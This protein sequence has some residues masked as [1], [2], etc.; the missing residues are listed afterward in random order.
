MGNKSICSTRLTTGTTRHSY[1]TKGF[2]TLSGEWPYRLLRLRHYTDTANASPDAIDEN[3]LAVLVV[4]IEH[5][6]DHTLWSRMLEVLES[7]VSSG[8]PGDPLAQEVV[9]REFPG[10]GFLFARTRDHR[11]VQRSARSIPAGRVR[12][13]EGGAGFRRTPAEE[14]SMLLHSD[15]GS[16]A[17]YESAAERSERR[18]ALV[19]EL[20]TGDP[21]ALR[22][23][24][25]DA[26]SSRMRVPAILL[27]VDAAMN[28]IADASTLLAGALTRPDDPATA[29]KYLREAYPDRKI[30]ASVKRA[31][32]EAAVRLFDESACI[33]FD[34]QRFRGVED[35][36]ATSRSAS[37]R[38][39]LLVARPAPSSDAQSLLFAAILSGYT[40]VDG[41]PLLQARRELKN[42]EP[43]DAS[44]LIASAARRVT[45]ARSRGERPQE[46]LAALPWSDL[47]ALSS[48]PRPELE[49]LLT[50]GARLAK[51]LRELRRDPA[52]VDTYREDRRLRRR[53]RGLT[54]D[55]PGYLRDATPERIRAFFA[56]PSYAPLLE[57]DDETPDWLSLLDDDD[58]SGYESAERLPRPP[59]RPMPPEV[60]R[61]LAAKEELQTF[62]SS[63]DFRAFNKAARPLEDALRTNQS[64]LR[65]LRKS[66]RP[67]NPDIW[68][69][70]APTMS[71][72]ETLSLL[73]SFE[74]S[75]V[76][77]ELVD[78][79]RE[80]IEHGR[81]Q[82]PDILRAARGAV[83]GSPDADAG[84]RDPW[85][86]FDSSWTAKPRSFWEP[87]LDEVLESRLDEKLP[88]L[89][90]RLL[91]LVDGSG[92]MSAEVSGRKNDAR[93]EGYSS[94]SCAEVAAFAASAIASRCAVRPDLYVYDTSAVKVDLDGSRGVLDAVRTVISNVRGGGTDTETVMA[95]NYDGHDLVVVLTDEQTSWLPGQP[96]ASRYRGYRDSGPAKQLPADTKVVTV[97]LAG[98]EASQG[99]GTRPGFVGISGWSEALFE[100]VA[101][102][103]NS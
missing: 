25:A 83:L 49:E 29:L 88:S 48:G 36:S 12:T 47:V 84:S 37:F 73:S 77:E 10:M 60:A 7:V 103:A 22:R 34:V 59:A 3:G 93:A 54:K 92:S 72:V 81:F 82:I 18:R 66:S 39:V 11:R 1:K 20:A 8:F 57:V 68:R 87:V 99:A 96:T 19:H 101:T 46:P 75:G 94:L 70:T 56:P 6:S 30:P 26:Q 17:F 89:P 63:E 21:E 24:A 97:N 91:I 43:D 85:R 58:R 42:L 86:S 69:L 41:L 35:R 79:V 28:G 90:G 4:P 23:V 52:F 14:L 2:F 32:A 38:D 61:L 65:T 76:A 100:A 40:Q 50:E 78:V 98:F 5:A 74:R 27:G 44:V 64:A 16:D 31:L 71:A 53:V 55:V 13:G 33:R 9:D 67:V 95:E 45:E 80:R 62:R 51:E 102:S 15:R